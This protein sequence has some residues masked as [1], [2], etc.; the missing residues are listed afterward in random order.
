MKIAAVASSG[1]LAPTVL[2]QD[3]LAKETGSNESLIDDLV[4]T[5]VDDEERTF[6]IRVTETSGNAESVVFEEEATVASGNS[7][8]YTTAFPRG[9]ESRVS[10]ETDDERSATRDTTVVGQFPLTYGFEV[11]AKPELLAIYSRHVDP[12]LDQWGDN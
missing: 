4:V 2:S 10:I 3:A 8:S 12:G 5:N 6:T 7:I 1:T 9:E 11:A